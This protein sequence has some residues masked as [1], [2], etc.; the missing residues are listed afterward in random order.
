MTMFGRRYHCDSCRETDN[1]IREAGYRLV[2]MRRWAVDRWTK[3]GS[4]DFLVNR[5]ESWASFNDVLQVAAARND[6]APDATAYVVVEEPYA[7]QLPN[8][9]KESA[10]ANNVV[11][12]STAEFDRRARAGTL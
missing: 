7:S 11:V 2:R 6:E 12:L 3:A 4:R 1:R 10:A 8:V 5:P 9:T